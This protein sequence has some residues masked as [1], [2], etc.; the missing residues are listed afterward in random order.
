[1]VNNL[2]FQSWIICTVWTYYAYNRY[3]YTIHDSFLNVYL[4]KN[5]KDGRSNMGPALLQVYN[6][7]CSATVP[8][9]K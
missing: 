4:K 3:K 1:M 8:V 6:V 7:I 9:E 2:V 5:Q